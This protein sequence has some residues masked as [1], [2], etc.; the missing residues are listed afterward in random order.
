MNLPD[1]PAFLPELNLDLDLSL[2]NIPTEFSRGSSIISPAFGESSAPSERTEDI[3]EPQL[4]FPSA[5]TPVPF[6]AGA[7]FGTSSAIQSTGAAGRPATFEELGV[8]EDPLFDVD[9][10]GEIVHLPTAAEKEI[11]RGISLAAPGDT[12]AT[13]R[14][15]AGTIGPI[16]LDFDQN[17]IFGVSFSTRL[18]L[19]R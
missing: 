14:T 10:A 4:V 3:E 1:D 7:G 9:D 15:S 13:S 8:I 6:S 16:D 12:R 18:V 11:E 19:I 2:F 17:D 5:D